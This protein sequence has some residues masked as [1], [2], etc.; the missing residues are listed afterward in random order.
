LERV[1]PSTPRAVALACSLDSDSSRPGRSS[2]VRSAVLHITV[3]WIALVAANP[4][5]ALM[6]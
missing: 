6:D 4:F 2:E 3:I 1:K 5:G